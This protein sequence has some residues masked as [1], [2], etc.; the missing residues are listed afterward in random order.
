MPAT[1]FALVLAAAALHALWNL[2]LARAKDTEAAAAAAL[3]ISVLLFAPAAVLTW[4]VEREAIPY[5][6]AS[7]VLHLTYF[8]LLM[9]G[10]RRAD[11]S[12]V[13]PL[14][15]GLAPV[16]VLLVGFSALGED[17]SA[18]QALGVLLIAGGVVLVRGLGRVAAGRGVALAAAT[19]VVIAGYTLVDNAGIRHASPLPYLELALVVPA[20]AYLA[21]IVRVRGRDA[22]RAEVGV[23]TAVAGAAMFAAYALVL[24][25]LA[26]APAAPV[27]ALRET[28]VVIAAAAAAV[29]LR[30]D[31]GPARITGAALVA[32]GIIAIGAG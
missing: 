22:V 14:S 3:P 11:L 25:A 19:A 10:Y 21:S 6:A 32:A 24:A 31:V 13:Y 18:L 1:V 16:I 7:S 8:A 30:E 20:F 12:L 4:D 9:A 26:L 29:T 28:S 5:I 23:A 2:L 27:A 15:R 17:V